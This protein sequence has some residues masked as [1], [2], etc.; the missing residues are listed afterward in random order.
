MNELLQEVPEIHVEE[1][2]VKRSLYLWRMWLNLG[3]CEAIKQQIRTK[4]MDK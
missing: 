2:F 1:G 3:R 4:V